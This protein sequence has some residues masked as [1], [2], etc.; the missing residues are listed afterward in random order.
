MAITRSLP[1]TKYETA[2]QE[3]VFKILGRSVLHITET[4]RLA[5]TIDGWSG[6]TERPTGYYA[7]TRQT[8]KSPYFYHLENFFRVLAK[9]GAQSE[10]ACPA[11]HAWTTL[12]CMD[13]LQQSIDQRR[14]VEI[15]AADFAV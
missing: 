1:G 4:S 8:D 5:D 7:F 14:E 3:G 15:T 6:P 11:E 2:W 13:K 10:L 12:V 9:K